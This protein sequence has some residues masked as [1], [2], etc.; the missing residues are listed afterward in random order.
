MHDPCN[1]ETALPGLWHQP[2][3]PIRFISALGPFRESLKVTYTP[4]DLPGLV[5]VV[6]CGI[7]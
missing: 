3:R 2:A 5:H 1:H 6:C 7:W 4:S